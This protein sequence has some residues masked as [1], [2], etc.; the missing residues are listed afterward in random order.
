MQ[1]QSRQDGDGRPDLDQEDAV[2]D[3][4]RDA[5]RGIDFGSVLIKIHQGRVVGL[6]TSTK[7]R[8]ED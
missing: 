1:R 4:V 8:L 7:V 6:E 5:I 2:L 3:A